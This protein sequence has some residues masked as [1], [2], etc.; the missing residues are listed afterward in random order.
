MLFKNNISELFTR[1]E[2]RYFK[3]EL[4]NWHFKLN[5]ISGESY[6]YVRSS[7]FNSAWCIAVSCL[8]EIKFS[9]MSKLVQS[10]RPDYIIPTTFL[11]L[12]NNSIVLYI[13]VKKLCKANFKTDIHPIS[14]SI[15]NSTC[16]KIIKVYF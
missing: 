16:M 12:Y 2:N 9:H 11:S 4:N 14:K 15:P 5:I 7:N 6:I 13:K 3:L 8:L 10:Y 1:N